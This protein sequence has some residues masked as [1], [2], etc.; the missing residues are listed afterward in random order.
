M[1]SR[2]NRSQ[3]AYNYSNKHSTFVISQESIGYY[4][5]ITRFNVNINVKVMHP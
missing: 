1:E 3:I 5:I 4:W 2:L